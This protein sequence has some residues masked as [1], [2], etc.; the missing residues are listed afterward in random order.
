MCGTA[1]ATRFLLNH[2]VVVDMP[3][4]LDMFAE[5]KPPRKTP[6]KL[7]H[8]CDAGGCCEEDGNGAMVCMSCKRCGYE[9]E[10]LYLASVTEAKRG[11]PCPVCNKPKGNLI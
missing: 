6:S 4:T 5:L 2:F 1:Q 9:S 11:K 7:M 3:R 8:V 10:W